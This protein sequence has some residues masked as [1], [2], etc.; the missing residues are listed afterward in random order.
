VRFTPGLS[1]AEVR[2]LL[3]SV[4]LRARL[5]IPFHGKHT[6]AQLAAAQRD[7]DWFGPHAVA[8]MRPQLE[9]L[10][11]P[12]EA[13]VFE[14]TVRRFHA[15]EVSPDEMAFCHGDIHGYN[16]AMGEDALGARIVG[17]FDLECTGILDIHE[18]FFRLSLVSEDLVKRVMAAY[19]ALPGQTHALDRDRIALFYRAFLFHLMVGKGGERLAHLKR[20]LR[21][22]L[23]YYEK[24]YGGLGA[25]CHE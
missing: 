12:A 14:D 15:R 24:A 2:Q 3:I 7:H 4:P 16:V 13:Q 8:E 10:L 1:E 9:P 21:K 5:Q 20:L 17:V 22:H 23:V 19:Q 25:S 11:D 6:A 18:D